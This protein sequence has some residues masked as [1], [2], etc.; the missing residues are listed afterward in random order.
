MGPRCEGNGI[1]V[2]VRKSFLVWILGVGDVFECGLVA[3]R[4][5]VIGDPPAVEAGL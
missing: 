3:I 1:R 4:N 2:A 5:D